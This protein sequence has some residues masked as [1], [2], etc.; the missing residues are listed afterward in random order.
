MR[1]IS[2]HIC[3]KAPRLARAPGGQR[4]S[5]EARLGPAGL[6]HR[7]VREGRGDQQGAPRRGTEW[8][9]ARLQQASWGEGSQCVQRK[10]E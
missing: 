4:R 5:K 3:V 9:E 2:P 10:P 1:G 6:R 8:W 7:G